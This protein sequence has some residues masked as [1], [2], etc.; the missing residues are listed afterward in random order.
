M[1]GD[2]LADDQVDA[3]GDQSQG[4]GLTQAAAFPTDESVPQGGELVDGTLGDERQG[5]GRGDRIG[6]DPVG[7]AAGEGQ[8]QDD[9]ADDGRVCEVLAQAAEE[10]LDHHDGKEIADQDDPVG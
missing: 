3:A 6:E 2:D 5:G 4:A 1:P 9:T 8:E 7:H 10:L